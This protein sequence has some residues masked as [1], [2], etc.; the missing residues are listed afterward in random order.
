M[1]EDVKR[2]IMENKRR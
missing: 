2:R 1:E